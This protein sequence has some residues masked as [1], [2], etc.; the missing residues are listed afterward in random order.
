MKRKLGLLPLLLTIA[1]RTTSG[2]FRRQTLRLMKLKTLLS[3]AASLA[4]S[5]SA[6]ADFII[7]GGKA[8]KVHNGMVD[9][10]LRYE[11]KPVDGLDYF[12]IYPVESKYMV[13]ATAFYPQRDMIDVLEKYVH[14]WFYPLELKQNEIRFSLPADIMQLDNGTEFI[15]AV[16]QSTSYL[17]KYYFHGFVGETFWEE[18]Q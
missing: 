2:V 18:V 14:E 17:W 9:F 7:T 4:L 6:H 1:A 16:F 8:S 3:L 5:L 11:G 15:V 10:V 12:S 13:H